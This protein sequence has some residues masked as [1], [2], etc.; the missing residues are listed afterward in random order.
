MIGKERQTFITYLT[1]DHETSRKTWN[2]GSESESLIA[3]GTMLGLEAAARYAG[4]DTLSRDLAD[5]R[6]RDCRTMEG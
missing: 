4:M 5:L 1:E 3:W 2:A 6:R